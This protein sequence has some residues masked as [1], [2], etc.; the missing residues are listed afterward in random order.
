VGFQ[1]TIPAFEREKTVHALNREA[2]VTGN[3]KQENELIVLLSSTSK[4]KVDLLANLACVH[5]I[6][7]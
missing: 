7:T 2:T 1:P 3:S 6:S 5:C 4:K